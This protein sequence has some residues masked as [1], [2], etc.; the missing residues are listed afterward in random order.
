M[1]TA[2][3]NFPETP[4]FLRVESSEEQTLIHVDHNEW[5]GSLRIKKPTYRLR[6][7]IAK[8]KALYL[9]ET[10]SVGETLDADAYAHAALFVEPAKGEA[11]R[12]ETLE[13]AK[14]IFALYWEI[15]RFLERRQAA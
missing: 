15:Q 10:S 14:L 9:C 5:Q 4:D 12:I 6:M 13:D 8:L 7:E 11:W 1:T 2:Q 3:D